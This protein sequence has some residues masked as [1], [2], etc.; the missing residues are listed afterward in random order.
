MNCP[1]CAEQVK[2]SAI[3]CKHCG[4]DLYVI[5][6]LMDKLDE[7]TKRLQAFEAAYPTG[8]PPVSVNLAPPAARS[9]LPGIDPLAAVAMTFILFVL[10]HAIIIVEYSL[11]LVFLRVVSI[12][13]PLVFGFLCRETSRRTMVAE[14]LFGVVVAVLSILVMSKVVGKLDQVPVLPRNS[15]E[16]RE[17]IEYGASIAFGFFTGAIIRHTVIA[18][19]SSSATPNRVIR[20]ISTRISEKLGGSGRFQNEDHSIRGIRG[21]CGFIGDHVVDHRAQSLLLRV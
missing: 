3:V 1:Y 6:P 16:W 12:V 11:P 13:V 21:G 20:M 5:R 15:Y 8:A 18:M 17:F 2:D 9:S 7:A 14:F 19:R 10:A 4:R